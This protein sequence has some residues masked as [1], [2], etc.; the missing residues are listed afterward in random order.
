MRIYVPGNVQVIQLSPRTGLSGDSLPQGGCPAN[1]PP[2]G[3]TKATKVSI[4]PD[5]G[6]PHAQMCR[7]LLKALTVALSSGHTVVGGGCWEMDY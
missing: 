1:G 3:V 2:R 4:L 6:V 7:R 5:P